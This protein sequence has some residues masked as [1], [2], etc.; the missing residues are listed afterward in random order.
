MMDSKEKNFVSAVVYVHNSKDYIRLFL[1]RLSLVLNNNFEKYEI[2][3]VNDGS[4]DSSTDI[5]RQVSKD[6]P[7]CVLSIINMSYY[8]GIEA[9]MNAGIELAIGDFVFEFD[10]NCI[11]Y[12]LQLVVDVYFHSLKG[13]DIVSAGRKGQT[14]LASRL[15]YYL[16]NK[17]AGT[18]YKLQTETFRVLSRRAINR[19]RTMSKTIPYRK[20]LYANCGLKMDVV[21]YE[22]ITNNNVCSSKQQFK[23]KQD[24]AINTLVLFTDVAYKVSLALTFLMMLATLSMGLY[25]IIIYLLKQPVAGFTTI[26][27][28]MTGSFFGVF[29]VLAIIIKHLTIMVDL[30]YRK[31]E[32][33]VESIEKITQ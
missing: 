28:V 3:C 16:F 26:M 21:K 15:F 7:G 32:F 20:A 5:I 2:I 4:T 31:Q 1:E 22:P 10:S 24:T 18:Q 14:A 9:S 13:Y 29:A 27:L 6:I 17:S 23:N 12:D 8:Q 30:V 25:T 33:I 11:D 19:I